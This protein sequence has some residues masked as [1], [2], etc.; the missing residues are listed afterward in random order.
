MSDIIGC[1]KLA[2]IVGCLSHSPDIICDMLTFRSPLELVYLDENDT[3]SHHIQRQF[4]KM[5][6]PNENFTFSNE[7]Q[8]YLLN[9]TEMETGCPVRL[10]YFL[11]PFIL[12][13][14]AISMSYFNIGVAEYLLSA[15]I[16]YYLIKILSVDATHY[17]VFTTITIFPTSLRFLFGMIVDTLSF[18]GYRRKPWNMLGWLAY[19]ILMVHLYTYSNPSLAALTIGLFGSTF[20][21]L[22]ISVCNDAQW[23]ERANRFESNEL[24]GSIQS[25]VHGIKSFGYVVGSLISGLVFNLYSWGWGLAISELFLFSALLPASLFI[26]FWWHSAELKSCIPIPSVYTTMVT[27]A[28]TLALDA[29]RLPMVFIGFHSL[30]Q[31]QN[32]SWN[33]F[34]VQGLDF[35]AFHLVLLTVCGSL[36]FFSVS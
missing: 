17:S 6:T 21:L 13:N 34:L 31:V 23:V 9:K 4:P 32:P 11:S 8:Q 1:H 7:E 5:T 33:I 12:P 19:I 16:V 24:K 35:N 14:L 36:G 25:S 30:L 20:C 18:L 15:P 26:P 22:F 27:I 3:R 10:P 29:V 2:R 28:D